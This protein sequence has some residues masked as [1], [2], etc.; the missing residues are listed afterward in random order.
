MKF[1]HHTHQTHE[2]DSGGGV[3]RVCMCVS[4]CAPACSTHYLSKQTAYSLV[5][6]RL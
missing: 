2:L 5:G 3:W 4:V 1:Q 6:R